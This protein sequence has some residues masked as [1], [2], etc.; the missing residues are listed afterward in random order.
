MASGSGTTHATPPPVL[1]FQV[2]KPAPP[3]QIVEP[4]PFSQ[5]T[6]PAPPSQIAEPITLSQVDEPTP[7]PLQDAPRPPFTQISS[8]PDVLS[9]SPT[10]EF[11]FAFS[12]DIAPIA[13]LPSGSGTNG[14][15]NP[16]NEDSLGVRAPGWYPIVATNISFIENSCAK[17]T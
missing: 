12:R 10:P 11:S 14:T 2:T 3:S 7:V 13:N 9:H 4:A 17:R 6:E 8:V 1:P 5:V 16:S 15:E